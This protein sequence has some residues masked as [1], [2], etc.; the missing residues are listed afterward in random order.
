MSHT[1]TRLVSVATIVGDDVT[2]R[3]WALSASQQHR[4]VELLT[5]YLGEPEVDVIV[6]GDAVRE[7]AEVGER[8]GLTMFAEPPPDPEADRLDREMQS[9]SRQIAFRR[10][11]DGCVEFGVMYG[12][13]L[14]DE[15]TENGTRYHD[16]VA[17]AM[18]PG[19]TVVLLEEDFERWIAGLGRWW[20]SEKSKGEESSD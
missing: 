14:G 20:E 7:A 5:K 9:S 1:K 3:M 4:V 18:V 6:P 16:P 8:H 12:S 2:Q 10:L 17:V 15:H 19:S 11:R 13:P